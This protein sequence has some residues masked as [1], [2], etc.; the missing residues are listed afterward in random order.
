METLE[1]ITRRRAIRQFD[2]NHRMEEHEIERLLSLAMLSPTA[3][4][5]QNWRFVVVRDPELRKRM[6]AVAWN[7]AQVTDASLFVILCADLQAWAKEPARY[8]CNAPEAQRTMIL[9]TME[10]CYTGN[11]AGQRDEAV[12]SCAMAAQTLMLA[13]TGMGYESCP[14]SGFDFTAMGELINLPPD[15]VIVM[16]VAIGKGLQ[17]AGPRS[18]QLPLAEVVF[19]NGF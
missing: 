8:W 16:S 17:P 10:R 13:A 15:H 4:N 5:L 1:A 6:R 7:Q 19:D 3:F 2:S 9:A 12:R 14:I 18:G 11:P